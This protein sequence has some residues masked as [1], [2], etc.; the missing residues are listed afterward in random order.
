MGAPHFSVPQPPLGVLS[1]MRTACS[2][3]LH[4]EMGVFGSKLLGLFE[5]L[6]IF[7]HLNVL[8]W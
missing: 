2:P 1:Q 7:S 5:S 3:H 4:L 6:N 8:S